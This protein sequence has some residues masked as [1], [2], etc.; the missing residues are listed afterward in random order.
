M[1]IVAGNECLVQD[2]V[3]RTAHITRLDGVQ[4]RPDTEKFAGFVDRIRRK[5]LRLLSHQSKR[6]MII[7]RLGRAPTTRSCGDLLYSLF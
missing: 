5:I 7:S 2:I 4:R 1:R 6:P 3:G